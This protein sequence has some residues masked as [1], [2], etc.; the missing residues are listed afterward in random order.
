MKPLQE[1]SSFFRNKSNALDD[2]RTC[3]KL[4]AIAKDEGPYIPQWVY[5]HFRMGID[6]IEI[7]INNTT[8]NSKEICKKI[9]KNNRRFTYI[10]GDKLYKKSQQS[11]QNYQRAAYNKSLKRSKR[12]I[13]SATHILLLDLDE[14]LINR[15]SGDSIKRLISSRPDVDVFSFLWYFEFWNNSKKTFSDPIIDNHV[16][17]R[18]PH[19]KSLAKISKNL[20]SFGIHN[21]DF[22]PGHTPVNLLSDTNIHL[23]EQNTSHRRGLLNHNV[24]ETLDKEVTEGWYI[25]HCVYR[26]QTEYLASL[27]RATVDH[28]DPIKRNRWGLNNPRGS[29][30][31][32]ARS[33]GRIRYAIG[34]YVFL[35]RH[36]L[37]YELCTAQ[38]QLVRRLEKLDTLLKKQPSLLEK[39]SQVFIGTTYQNKD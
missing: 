13:D 24:L 31:K 22:K 3:I 7:H 32:L 18:N 26:S 29:K 34:L 2:R 27:I 16:G 28:P 36:Q 6:L 10:N 30:L 39:Y 35:I 38:K 21:A 20:M 25:L 33:N 8:D 19:V 11:R 14:Y 1:I 4:V 12:G 9:S 17:I 5:H 15:H 37:R 23:I